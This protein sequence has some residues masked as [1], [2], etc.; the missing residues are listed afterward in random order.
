MINSDGQRAEEMDGCEFSLRLQYSPLSQFLVHP[1]VGGRDTCPESRV[2]L[3]QRS[4]GLEEP[5][6]SSAQIYNPHSLKCG[7][8][9]DLTF[10]L[11]LSEAC[12]Q[13]PTKDRLNL[14]SL[15]C[16]LG[17]KST[18]KLL[19]HNSDTERSSF[20]SQTKQVL[21]S[22]ALVTV[23]APPAPPRCKAHF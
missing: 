2:R 18:L 19:R 22:A 6:Y 10:R 23:K 7:L 20:P 14:Q 4:K 17:V 3:S 16:A 9:A 1:M 11:H 12:G 8:I 15:L 13:L 5:L 21:C